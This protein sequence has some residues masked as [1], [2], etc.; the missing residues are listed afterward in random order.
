LI[1]PNTASTAAPSAEDDARYPYWRRNLLVL[2]PANLL[3]GLGF[4]LSWPFVPLMVRGLGVRENLETWVGHMLL[5]FYLVSFFVNPLWG[6]IADHYGRKLMILR[7]MLG[8]GCAMMLVPFA[9]TP[10]WFAA[11]FMLIA[12]FNGFTPAGVALLVANTPPARI[13]RAVSLAQTG[14]LVGQALGPAVGAVLAALIDHQHWLFWISGGLMLSGGILAA[15][16]VREVEQLAPGPWRPR[17][18]SSLRELLKAP[19]IGVLFLLS[20]LF[21]VMWFGSVTNISVFVIQLLEAGGTDADA[22]TE[23]YWIGAAAVAT[24]VSMLIATPVWGRITDRIGPG[25]VLAF[26]TAATVVTHLPLLVLETPLQLV[27]SRIAF[28]L[29]AAGMP[30]AT[31][32]LLRTYTPPGMDSRAISYAT[33]FHFFAMGLAP[34]LAGLIGPL[35]GMRAYFALTIVLMIGGLAAWLYVERK[36]APRQ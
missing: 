24:A 35:F 32:H 4:S 11:T 36:A 16:F 6:G 23:A 26:C 10:L 27:I 28:G 2:P 22:A 33:A 34:F 31:Y 17:W 3:C 29:T 7:A 9:S 20:F 12:V 8:M 1:T 13:G 14:G 19:R 15:L 30:T 21:A 18:L 5:V 25:R